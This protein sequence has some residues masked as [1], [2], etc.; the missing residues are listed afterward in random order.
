MSRFIIIQEAGSDQLLLVDKD[1]KTVEEIDASLLDEMDDDETGAAIR[2]ARDGG[3]PLLQGI[4]AAIAG[5]QRLELSGRY[6]Y[7][8]AA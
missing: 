3:E 6:Y 7:S 2:A 1:S 4:T 8:S 5:T